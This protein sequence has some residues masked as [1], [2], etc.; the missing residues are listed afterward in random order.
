MKYIVMSGEERTLLALGLALSFYT[1]W[2]LGA[3]D[4]ATPTDCAVGSGVLSVRRAVFLFALFSSL[5]ALTHGYMVMKTIGKGIVP[6]V[7]LVGCITTTLAACVWV[8]L[9]SLRGLDI[10]ITYSVVSSVLGYGLVRYGLEG[11]NL[12][13]LAKIFL[14]WAASPLCS[15]MLAFITYKVVSRVLTPYAGNL[16]TRRLLSCLL[17]AA[18]CFSAYSFGA[19]DV[20]NA[21]GVY[22]SVSEKVGRVPGKEAMFLLALLGSI[23]IALGGLTLGPRV[24]DAVAFRITRL[25]LLAGFAAELSNA[26]VVYLFTA[27]PY[28]LFGYGLPIST[29]VASNGS[30][31]GVGI[32]AN[33]LRSINLRTVARLVATWVLT[34]PCTMLLSGCFYALALGTLGLA[35]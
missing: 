16:R 30:I 21:T 31:I 3:N 32:A 10:S 33:G 27:L 24:I 8:T 23:G 25:D 17:I 19:N 4:A 15:L 28:T 14:S 1:A 26:L 22:V 5:G 7:D 29:S 35:P 13:V 12:G 34:V 11:T 9:C 2:T 20:A 6:E 18:L